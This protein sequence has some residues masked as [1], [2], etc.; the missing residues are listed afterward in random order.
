MHRPHCCFFLI[1]SRC[2]QELSSVFAQQILSTGI[3]YSFPVLRVSGIATP[4]YIFKMRYL[5]ILRKLI[6]EALIKTWWSLYA[7]TNHSDKI[8]RTRL[9]WGCKLAH[10]NAHAED[11]MLKLLA[12]NR[13]FIFVWRQTGNKTEIAFKGKGSKG[14]LNSEK[15]LG[16]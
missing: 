5:H 9:C 11:A 12:L 1:K 2:N 6:M 8:K 3:N 7:G 15:K 13:V 10:G 14:V 16:K 4:L